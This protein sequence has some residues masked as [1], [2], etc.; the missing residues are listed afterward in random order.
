MSR[1]DELKPNTIGNIYWEHERKSAV[2]RVLEPSDYELGCQAMLNDMEFTLV[3]E[4]IHLVFRSVRCTNL[5]TP[6]E[7]VF[8]NR[9]TEALLNSD[10]AHDDPRLAHKSEPAHVWRP[11]AAPAFTRAVKHRSTPS[12]SSEDCGELA[13]R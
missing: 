1:S 7:E 13:N 8:V 3:H 5:D 2:V 11:P 4:L 6:A 10:R 9:I 12:C